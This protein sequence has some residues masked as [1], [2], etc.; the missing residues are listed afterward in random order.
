LALP[1]W[2]EQKGTQGM[3]KGLTIGKVAK[4]SG[5]GVEAIRFYEREGIIL[6]P[7][8]RAGSFREYSGDVVYRLRFIKR[9]QDLGFSLS[10]IEELLS[11]RAKRGSCKIIKQRA[12]QKLMQIEEKI[13]DLRRIQ[14]A[15]LKVKATC[16]TQN[17]SEECPVLEGFYA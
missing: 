2:L 6:Q 14:S 4:L 11:L 1:Q 13:S 16:E 12:E 7:K 5:V 8:R 10:E 3:T 17:P 15:L 9:A